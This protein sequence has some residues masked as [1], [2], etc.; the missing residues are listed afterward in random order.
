MKKKVALVVR[1]TVFVLVVRSQIKLPVHKNYQYF[2]KLW[3]NTVFMLMILTY[4]NFTQK[5]RIG[6]VAKHETTIFGVFIIMGIREKVHLYPNLI[7]P[8]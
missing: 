1:E 5:K 6:C 4:F 2:N 8:V 7:H 3:T